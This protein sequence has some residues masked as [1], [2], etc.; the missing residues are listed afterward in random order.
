MQAPSSVRLSSSVRRPHSSNVLFPEN[1]GPIKAKKKKKKK[2]TEPPWADG[3]NENL[4]ATSGSF[5][6]DGHHA[7]MW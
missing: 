4:L 7:H 3:K 6:Q 2:K 1:L 5:D